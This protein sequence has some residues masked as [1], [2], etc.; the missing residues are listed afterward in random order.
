MQ[1]LAD[2]FQ[3]PYR[4]NVLSVKGLEDLLA[5]PEAS[6]GATTNGNC[7]RS[8][9]LSGASSSLIDAFESANNSS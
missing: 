9:D 1:G 5:S 7:D 2:L 3:S 4:P 6:V 8:F